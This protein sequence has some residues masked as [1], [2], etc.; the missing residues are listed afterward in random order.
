MRSGFRSRR[1]A[2]ACA[3]PGQAGDVDVPVNDDAGWQVYGLV[4]QAVQDLAVTLGG[5]E[6]WGTISRRAGLDQTTFVAMQT[7]DDAVT[8][9]LVEAASEV[10]GMTQDEVLEA[11]GE[12]WIVYTGRS[13]YGP[14]FA[15]MGS[16]LPEFLGNVDAMHA[17][18]A[19]SMPELRPPSFSCEQLDQQRILV[20]YW[21]ERTGLAPMVTGLLKGLGVLFDVPVSVAHV[22]SSQPADHQ[23]FLIT[24]HPRVALP[25]PAG[26]RDIGAPIAG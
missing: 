16:T 19:L 3:G 26:R 4:N 2:T 7:Y 13:G 23:L 10:L 11:F 20:R 22:A 1:N 17:R 24:P 21:S 8:F 6:L 14:L 15:A 9:A 5:N 12:H 18:I 25:H